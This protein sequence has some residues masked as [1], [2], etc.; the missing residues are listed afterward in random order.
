MKLLSGALFTLSIISPVF[1]QPV[2]GETFMGLYIQNQRIGYSRSFQA[3]DTSKGPGIFRSDSL[4]VMDAALLGTPLK[5]RIDGSTWLKNSQPVRMKFKVSSAG[6]NQTVEAQFRAKDV[7]VNVEN[8][9]KKTRSILVKP[10]GDIVDDPMT[11]LIAG[12]SPVGTRKVVYVFDPMT[13]SFVRNEVVVSKP[14]SIETSNGTVNAT[15]ID[16]LDPRMTTTVFL[17]AKGDFIKATS[18]MGIEMRPLGR[19]EAL[20]AL[21]AGTSVD[22]ASATLIRPEGEIDAPR[23][24]RKVSLLVQGRSLEAVPSDENQTVTKTD[25]GYKVDIHPTE[26]SNAPYPVAA[27]GQEGFLK[28]SLLLSSDAPR[29]QNLAARLTK[30]KTTLLSAAR[31]IHDFVQTTMVPN[32]GMGVLRN[33]EEVLDRKEGV[34]RDYAVLTTTLLRSAKIPAR[35]VGGM[36]FADGAFYYHA[37]SEAWDGENWVGIDSTLPEF[38]ISAAH[39]KLSDGN[40]DKAFSFPFL[41]GTRIKVL[42]SQMR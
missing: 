4:T 2:P 38:R 1:A 26:M 10:K 37:W 18:G 20:A 33:A 6:L 3:A 17:T 16:I 22:L 25:D 41:E 34:C 19:Q 35:L 8:V 30:G 31:A 28:Q 42:S 32:A 21:P 29:M 11:S 24:T 5:L 39:L 23:S 36:V 13:V 15:V 12:H 14:Q 40:V 9:G 7:V 27:N